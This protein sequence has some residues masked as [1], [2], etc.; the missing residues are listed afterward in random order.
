MGEE[1]E[2][3][4]NE[5]AGSPRTSRSRSQIN[6]E[7]V[8]KHIKSPSTAASGFENLPLEFLDLIASHL[9]TRSLARLSLVSNIFEAP[10]YHKLFKHLLLEER[11]EEGRLRT[12]ETTNLVTFDWIAV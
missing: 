1:E 4:N 5:E 6:Y 9:E 3:R 11:L 2:A 12:V 7:N 10:T 8:M